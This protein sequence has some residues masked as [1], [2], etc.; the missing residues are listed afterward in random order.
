[1]GAVLATAIE[2]VTGRIMEKVFGE[3][4]WDYTDKPFNF[5]GIL[6]LE[7]TLA[8]GLY[9]LI[10]FG[11]LHKFVERIASSIPFRIGRVVGSLL[12]LLYTVDFIITFRKEKNV[13]FSL[14]E[15]K[16]MLQRLIHR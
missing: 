11:V 10:L 2:L 4:W 14:E 5:K 12:I 8:W 15:M 3:V 6:C 9:T 7:S 1:M 13:S 16:K